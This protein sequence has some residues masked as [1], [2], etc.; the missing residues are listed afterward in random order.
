MNKTI[1]RQYFVTVALLVIA[2]SFGLCSQAVAEPTPYEIAEDEFTKAD[3]KLKAAYEDTLKA[4]SRLGT[5][6]NF[7]KAHQS[8]IEFR[9]AEAEFQTSIGNKGGIVYAHGRLVVATEL[10]NDR[11]QQLKRFKEEIERSSV[12]EQSK[13]DDELRRAEQNGVE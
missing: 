12:Q 6:D 8:W 5:R 7:I 3:E 10:T 4:I 1:L 13:I 11:I 2:A 9:D